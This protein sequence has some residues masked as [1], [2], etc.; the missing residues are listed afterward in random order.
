M[1]NIIINQMKAMAASGMICGMMTLVALPFAVPAHAQKKEITAAKDLVKAGKNLDQAQK[2]MEKLLADSANRGNK[3]IWGVLYD[4]VR[5]QYEQGNEKLYLK[6]AYDTA[7]LFNIARQLFVVAQQLDSVDAMPDKKGRLSIEYRKSHGDY[8][9][10]IRPNLFHGGTWFIR[11]QKYKE[12][13]QLFDQYI[14]CASQPLFAR[15]DYE[16]KDKH[17]PQAA[18]WAVYCGYKMKDPK[19]TLHYSY[20]ALKDKQHY[21]YMLQYLAETYRLEQDTARYVQTLKEGFKHAPDFPFFFPRLVE[22]YTDK[23]QMDVAM[24]VVDSAL[25]TAPD[26]DFYLYT[27]S[28]LLLNMGKNK[29]CIDICERLLAKSDSLPEVNY[30]AGLAWFN[31]AVELDKNV[32]VSSKRRQEILDSYK[33]ALP[34]L[35]KY[36]KLQPGMQS[37]WM[38]PL[39]TIYLNL[40]MG[41]EFDEIDKLMHKKSK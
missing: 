10:A 9:G 16:Q 19:A 1:K 40:N 5:K 20:E 28:S 18:Y 27:K 35:E 31:L 29:E 14:Q 33:K 25:V 7:K 41:K 11:K 17:L 34:Y 21:D 38:M 36:R 37:K 30:N 22:Y 26:N 15:Y 3:K 24:S 2:N 8:L 4:A 23:N 6:Q 32:Q 12:A 39:Y 13:Y